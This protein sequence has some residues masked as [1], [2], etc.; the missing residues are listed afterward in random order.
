MQTGTTE[1][2]SKDWQQTGF[3]DKSSGSASI[4]GDGRYVLF[5]SNATNLVQND[6]SRG[7]STGQVLRTYLR[8]RQAGTTN[9]VSVIDDGSPVTLFTSNSDLGQAINSPGTLI[10]FGTYQRLVPEDTD[11]KSDVYTRTLSN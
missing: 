3:G 8:D 4:S 11:N 7:T 5:A 10:G 2:I 9:I 6:Q 1:I